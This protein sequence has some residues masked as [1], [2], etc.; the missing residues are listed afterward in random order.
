[1]ILLRFRKRAVRIMMTP[2]STAVYKIPYSHPVPVN[3]KEL[4]AASFAIASNSFPTRKETTPPAASPTTETTKVHFPSS[5]NKA[6]DNFPLSV[7]SARKN[8][9]F[10]ALIAQKQVRG[11]DHENHTANHG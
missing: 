7:P 9:D 3:A 1:M 5:A 11:I 8:A 6:L 2:K 4:T 10:P